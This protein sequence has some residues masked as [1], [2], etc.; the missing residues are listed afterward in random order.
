MWSFVRDQPKPPTSL[1][2]HRRCAITNE[3]GRASWATAYQHPLLRLVVQACLVTALC[4]VVARLGGTLIVR[5]Q[6]VSPLWL[7]NVVLVSV[8]LFLRQKAWP[9]HLVAGLLGFFLFDL[10]TGVPIRSGIWLMLS[11]A[12]EVGVAVLCLRNYFQGT[13]RLNSIKALARYSFC[14]VFLAPFVG[15]FFGALS[16]R[17]GYWTI[18]KIAFF[19]EALGFL[20]LMP[21]ILGWAKEIP[22]WAQKPRGYHL[23]AIALLLAVVILG[24][25]AFA[26]GMSVSP[27]LLYSLV[28]LLLW[29]TLRFGSTGVSTSMTAICFVSIWGAVHGHGPFTELGARI[30]VLSLQLF[31]FFTAAPFMVLAAL[32]EERKDAEQALRQRETDFNE[33]QRLAQV[34]SWQWDAASDVVTWSEALY[35]MA[36]L[37]PSQPAVSYRDHW[38]LY[39]PESWARLQR[40]VA[41]ALSSATPYELELEMV[42]FSGPKKWVIARGEALSDNS[43]CVV[44]LRGTVQNISERRLVEEELRESEQRYNLAVHAG[45]MFAFDCDAATGVI[46]RSPQC[47]NILNWMD[48]PMHDS[49]RQFVKQVHPEDRNAYYVRG[50]YLSPENPTFQTRYRVIRPDGSIIWLEATGRAVFDGEGKT[51][52]I[53]GL[54]SDITDRKQAEELLSHL[55]SRLLEAQEQES[56]RIARELHDDLS[57]RMALI[58]IRLAEFQLGSPNLSPEA[59]RKLREIAE[60][61]TEVSTSIH[62]LSHQLHP[63]RLDTLGLV[64]S[65]KG[66]CREFSTE[67]HL[68]AIFV[69][70]NVPKRISKDVTLCL[71]RIAQEALRNVVKHSGATTAQME[72]SSEGDAIDLVVIDSGRGFSADSATV[73]AGLGLVSMRER[74]RLVRGQLSI[75]SSGGTRIHVRVPLHTKQQETSR[76]PQETVPQSKTW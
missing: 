21:A 23:E 32:V 45:K 70:R 17:T 43:G 3:S 13:P 41:E 75:E 50:T 29:S 58:S 30:N 42:P 76:L 69:H 24:Y 37:E 72:L 55:S 9:V 52:R 47:A 14:V 46:V 51:L 66:L 53:V 18:W 48:D 73:A 61:G 59:R 15:A 44:R 11:N 35:Q 8:L 62:N 19:S 33:A 71:F 39:T 49:D 31:L 54:V 7:G 40:A 38:K 22:V 2:F 10:Q 56:T 5:S 57:Q 6:L 67:H 20:T 63:S 16:S 64:A 25:F 74:L 65:L 26:S 12:V 28:P 27:T 1:D 36:G 60:I 4:N 68:D 34:G